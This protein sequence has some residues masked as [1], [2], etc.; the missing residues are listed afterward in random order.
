MKE[1]NSNYNRFMAETQ[2]TW[3]HYERVRKC[4]GNVGS[5][6]YWPERDS[7]ST[8][9]PGKG[10]RA[11]KYKALP[12]IAHNESEYIAKKL[13]KHLHNG[14]VLLGLNFGVPKD[15]LGFTEF[16]KIEAL[17]SMNDMSNQYGGKYGR[18]SLNVYLNEDYYSNV[19]NV[20]GDP[21]GYDE[22][23]CRYTEGAYMTDFF[24][25][26]IETKLDNK[27]SA[28]SKPTGMPSTDGEKLL[29]Q[30]RKEEFE[31]LIEV[32]AKGLK[33]ELDALGTPDNVIIAPMSARLR[34]KDVEDAICK[35]LERNVKFINCL[36]HYQSRSGNKPEKDKCIKHPLQA[37][38]ARNL[39]KANEGIEKIV[40]ERL[41]EQN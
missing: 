16:E 36:E 25:Y 20:V 30:Y 8:Q 3:E 40:Q 26:S 7:S 14:V 41:S 24:K 18:K 17:R 28:C 1:K 33:K 5:F 29:K 4:F 35:C 11:I 39:I 27:K 9:I 21:I 34:D 38:F 37:R 15:C 2:V 32:N 13:N 10:K 22:V 23:V 19:E 6:A 12:I 31:H